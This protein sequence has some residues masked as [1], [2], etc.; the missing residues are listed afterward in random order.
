VSLILQK[1]GLNESNID[2]YNPLNVDWL[3]ICCSMF[4][5]K[6]NELEPPHGSCNP[7]QGL[8]HC[9]LD[10]YTKHIVDL[11]GCKENYMKGSYMLCISLSIFTP[12]PVRSIIRSMMSKRMDW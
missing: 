5:F 7:D 2:I 11:C 1:N 3:S 10:C 8:W 6:I 12:Q 9:L 4:V